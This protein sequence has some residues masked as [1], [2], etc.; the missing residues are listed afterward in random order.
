MYRMWTDEEI[1][2]I[3]DNYKTVGDVAMAKH[4]NRTKNMVYGKRKMLGLER[5]KKEIYKIQQQNA[6]K[7]NFKYLHKGRKVGEVFYKENCQCYFIKCENNRAKP[8]HIYLYNKNFGTVPHN[9]KVVLR[10]GRYD[11]LDSYRLDNITLQDKNSILYR[12]AMSNI[13]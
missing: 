12:Y 10:N 4:L 13:I 6:I 2:Y 8:Y 7:R 11:N 1:Q 3:S 9:H 5:T